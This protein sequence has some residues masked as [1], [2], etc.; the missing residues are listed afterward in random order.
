MT[1]LDGI[2]PRVRSYLSEEEVIFQPYNAIQLKEILR[3]RATEAFMENVVQE[4]VIEKCAAF[5][6]REHG[7][8]R[9]ALD[10]LRV[11]GELAER[12]N[13]KKILLKHMD[14]ANEKVERDKI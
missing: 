9:R 1:F 3:K 7:D 4:G 12:S 6:A 2:D 14:E 10:L 5:A 8:A 11:A 13:S